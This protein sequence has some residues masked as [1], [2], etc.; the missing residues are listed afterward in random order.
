MIHGGANFSLILAYFSFTKYW[1]TND[2]AQQYD[3]INDKQD[4]WSQSILQAALA[5]IQG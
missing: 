4:Q 5:K 3:W 1:N 2:D